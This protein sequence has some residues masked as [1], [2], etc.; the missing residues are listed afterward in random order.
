MAPAAL[1]LEN[2]TRGTLVAQRI[3][4]GGSFW[5]RFRGL[6]GRTSLAAHD[7]LWLPDT[8]SIH[9]MFMRFP[10]D[11]AFLSKPDET[12]SR[13]VVAVRH[14]LP[15]WRGVVWWVRGAGGVVELPAGALVASRTEPGDT[16]KLRAA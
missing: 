16:V 3:D 15:P 8:S 12:G 9:M 4:S 10:I 6:M 11:C 1:V 5:A 2:A 14:G 13:R 7:G